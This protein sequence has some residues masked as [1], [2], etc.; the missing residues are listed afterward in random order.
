M[1]RVTRIAAEEELELILDRTRPTN[2]VDAHRILQRA[3][4]R[5]LPSA[6]EERFQRTVFTEGLPPS[7]AE[8]LLRLSTDSG[9]SDGD[10]RRVLAVPA[11][12]LQVRTDEQDAETLGA[13]EVPFF[14]FDRNRTVSR[15]QPIDTL[16][17]AMRAGPPAARRGVRRPEPTPEASLSPG[18]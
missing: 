11:F 6:L 9:L 14:A 4:I 5:G 16:L 2:S 13:S 3:G 7:D 10:M 15:A 17:A 8:T 18:P 12:R 1:A